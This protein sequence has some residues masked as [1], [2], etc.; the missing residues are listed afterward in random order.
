MKAD[1][2]S[3]EGTKVKSID[4]PNQ[5]NEEVREDIIKRAFLAFESRKRQPYG[6]YK[7]AGKRAAVRLS[8]RRHHYKGSYGRGI[9]RSPR[10][11]IVR[12]GSQ[13]IWVGAFAPNTVGGRRAH[14]PKSEKILERGINKKENTKGIRSAIAATVNKELVKKHGYITSNIPLVIEEK[15]ELINKT[16]DLKKVLEKLE[17]KEDIKRIKKKVREGRG[18]LRGRKYRTSKGPLIVVSKD[19]PL[20]KAVKNLHGFDASV[21]DSLNVGLLAPGSIPGRLVI[22]TFPALTRLEK[23]KLFTNQRTNK[24]DKRE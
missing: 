7:L 1:L 17:L 10:K 11:T 20:M 2:L 12:R 21:V 13:F 22:W 14:P 24:K 16:K 15:L 6:A 18:R 9:S 19:C 23:E 8:K 5:F 4:L 3:I